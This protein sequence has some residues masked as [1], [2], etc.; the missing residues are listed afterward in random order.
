MTQYLLDIPFEAALQQSVRLIQN[1]KLAVIQQSTELF[2]KI[3]E[4]S[5][6]TDSKLNIFFLNFV[7]VL[8]HY[9]S[10]NENLD[11]SFSKLAYFLG[12]FLHLQSQLPRWHQNHS[13]DIR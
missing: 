10:S 8:F 3:F 5:R 6:R 1:K 11:V 4:S 12:K 2:H 7:V 9:G 13:L